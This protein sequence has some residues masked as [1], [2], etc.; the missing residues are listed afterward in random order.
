M[1]YLRT[2]LLGVLIS[3][4]LPGCVSR[5]PQF[6]S[7][8]YQPDVLSQ[9]VLL[10]PYVYQGIINQ[11]DKVSLDDSLSY[12]VATMIDEQLPK[13]FIG[14][15]TLR[16]ITASPKTRRDLSDYLYRVRLNAEHKYK[17]TRRVRIPDH[18]SDELRQDNT[19]FVV[20]F[21]SDGYSR[22][23]GNYN[24]RV[25]AS[26]AVNTALA[27]STMYRAGN[28]G[29]RSNVTAYSSGL[30]FFVLDVQKQ[31]VLKY[32]RNS[33]AMMPVNSFTIRQHLT[34]LFMD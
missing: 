18:I 9:A 30:D 24:Q 1:Y 6:S 19:R 7:P 21:V 23:L 22:R 11:G 25:A 26:R 2:I 12:E 28:A 14:S 33:L 29:A 17:K 27:L 3:Y 34:I 8:D 32:K 4:A 16:R 10:S 5:P 15:D 13:Y 31:E 20:V